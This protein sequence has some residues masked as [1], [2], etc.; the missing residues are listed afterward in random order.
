MTNAGRRLSNALTVTLVERR[1]PWRVENWLSQRRLVQEYRAARADRW[2]RALWKPYIRP[3]SLVFDVGANLGDKAA[4]CRRLGARVVCVEPDPRTAGNL[5][6][7][8]ADDESVVVVEAGLGSAPGHFELHLSPY[9]TRSSFVV[10]RMKALGDDCG[11]DAVARVA[12]K[13]LDELIATHGRP[14]FCKIDVEGYEPEVLAGLSQPLPVIQF[15]F[16]GELLGD[17]AACLSRL[18][19]LGMRRFNAILHPAGGRWL[20]PTLDRWFLPESVS[21][22]ELLATLTGLQSHVLSGDLVAFESVNDAHRR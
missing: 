2:Q 1:L 11:W 5:R 6:Q 19:A 9:T 14:D 16:H 10:D 4:I 21:R 17:A 20:Q 18:E 15:E 7:R 22:D 12:V 8:F 3:N 13:T